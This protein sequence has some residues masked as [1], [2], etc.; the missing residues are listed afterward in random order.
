ME[1]M[2]REEEK[3]LLSV[4][5][6]IYN[7]EPYLHRCI[8]SILAQTFKGFEL[9]LIDDGSVDNSGNICDE[10]M[11][12]DKRIK[13]YH[14]KNS[15]SVVARKVG[16]AYACGKYIGFVDAD[17]YIEPVMFETL[18]TSIEVSGADFIHTG[19]IEENLDSSSPVLG[20][21]EGVIDL[22]QMEDRGKFLADYVLYAENKK[23]C[24]S[25]WTKLFKRELIVKCFSQLPEEQQFGEDL[26]CLCLC[27][28]ESKRILM[29][30]CTLYHYV[31]RENSLSHISK[32]DFII[33]NVGLCFC[34]VNILKKYYGIFDLYLKKCLCYYFARDY[35]GIIEMLNGK[36]IKMPFFYM[37][38]IDRFRGLRIVI[39]GAGG[40]GQDYYSQFCRYPDI[41][42]VAWIDSNW[43]KCQFEYAKVVSL[44]SLREDNYEKI[45]IAVKADVTAGK[46]ETLL[47]EHGVPKDKI[48]WESPTNVLDAGLLCKEI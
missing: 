25:V 29:R 1:K 23:I 7:A 27:I 47:L 42:I 5:V 35:M 33:K 28:L 34:L 39:Y 31:I 16:L 36:S 41:Q 2:I 20:F 17:D 18:L 14:I 30:R 32:E 4:V 43:Q 40:V 19:Y 46:I 26:L 21:E 3:Y 44:S 12:Q 8:D 38:N 6:P 11:L 48:Y 45:I 22:P 13:A 24:N 10:Y 15:G 37:K 9:I